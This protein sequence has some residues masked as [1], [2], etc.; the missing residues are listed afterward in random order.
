MALGAT[1]LMGVTGVAIDVASWEGTLRKMQGAA[2]Q[3]ALATLTV[4]NASGN[5]LTEAQRSFP[6]GLS[7]TARA[8]YSSSRS[9]SAPRMR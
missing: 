8:R 7:G 3:A 5:K 1:A 2:N 9:A 4:A 6:F